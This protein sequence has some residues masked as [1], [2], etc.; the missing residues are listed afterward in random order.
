MVHVTCV[1]RF[2][3]AK[4]VEFA[5]ATAPLLFVGRDTDDEA[6]DE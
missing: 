3:I 2:E 6:P 4:R 1:S 5:L